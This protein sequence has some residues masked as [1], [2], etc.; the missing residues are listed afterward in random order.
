MLHERFDRDQH[1]YLLRQ[2]FNIRQQSTVSAYVTA[3]SQLVDKLISYSPNADPLYFTQRFIDGLR[4]DI[5]AIVLVQRPHNFDTA[6][7]LALLQEEVGT[8]PKPRAQR[9]G[10]WQPTNKPR[11]PAAA[12]PLPLPPPPPRA[13]RPVVPAAAAPAGA[14]AQPAHQ[15]MAVVKAY[16]R[17]L[18][19]C[20]KCNAKWS[21]DHVCA[22]EI[23][24]AV[25]ALWDSFSSEDSLADSVEE[26]PTTEQC[27]LALSKAAISSVPVAHTVCLQGSLESIPVQI[28]VDLGSSS[29]FMNETL[30]SRLTVV[31][32]VPLASS[33]QVAGGA[34][35]V[36]TAVLRNVQWSISDF[37]F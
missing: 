16:R 5:K 27:C 26:F 21:K 15:T 32:S 8:A 23:L 33:V 7:R 3:F 19:L 12:A 4:F 28:L 18:G 14:A 1:E 13:D 31:E 24:H 30:V 20:Y 9:G 37:S 29:S 11:L 6:V 35:L 36:S 25:D 34:Q 10:D 22:P 17:A 2:M